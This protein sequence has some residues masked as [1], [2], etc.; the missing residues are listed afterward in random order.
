MSRSLPHVFTEQEIYML[1]TVLN[2]EIAEKQ[3][4]GEPSPVT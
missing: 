3:R 1:A 4:M 2:G